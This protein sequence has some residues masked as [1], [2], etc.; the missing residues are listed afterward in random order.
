[1]GN[2][3]KGLENLTKMISRQKTKYTTWL[4]LVEY[5]KCENRQVRKMGKV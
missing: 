3:P 1:M 5:I 4:L 2:V